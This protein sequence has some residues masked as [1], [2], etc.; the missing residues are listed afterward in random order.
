MKEV[1][2]LLLLTFALVLAGCGTT[3][4]VQ[5]PSGS[6][7]QAVMLGG[8]ST[9]SGFSFNTQINFG[10]SGALGLANFELLN[11]DTCFG[12]TAPA[13]A[14][15]LTGLNF[16]SADQ[17]TS[18]TFTFTM[19]S[20]AGDV[21]TLTSTG[22]T[23]TVNPNTSPATLSNGSITGFWALVPASGSS[24]VATSGNP[25]TMAQSTS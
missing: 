23:G 2:I 6:V 14:G 15:S 4:T 19:T 8:D 24:C 10:G 11:S 25:F 7:W 1:A 21:V 20:T 12:T 18:G 16:N 9:S 13:A 17:I 22:I 5:T 3:D